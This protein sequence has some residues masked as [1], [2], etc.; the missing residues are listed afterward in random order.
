MS[1]NNPQLPILPLVNDT[2]AYY[3]S[4]L[5]ATSG[6]SGTQYVSPSLSYVPVNNALG[7]TGNLTVNGTTFANNISEVS[8]NIN[9]T[10]NSII[11]N[12]ASA[13][14]FNITLNSNITTIQ[15]TNVQAAGFSTSF[16]IAFTGSGSSYA[17]I[18]P[19]NFKWPSG[20]APNVTST[21]TKKDIYLFFTVDGGLTWQAFTA[22]QNL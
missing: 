1:L 15:L 16:I 10:N 3:L 6:F 18:W 4:M 11:L 13:S 14:I 22:G 7:F 19:G 17:V 8:S 2:T 9:I 21:A 12:L 20:T 5:G